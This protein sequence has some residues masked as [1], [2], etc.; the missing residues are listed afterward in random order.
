MIVF[1]LAWLLSARGMQA[2]TLDT[3]VI[4]S[5]SIQGAIA[6]GVA[7]FKGIPYARPPVGDLRW[8]PPEDSISWDTV[9]DCRNFGPH[10]CQPESALGA[11]NNFFPESENCLT[12]NVYTRAPFRSENRAVLVFVNG[13]G[14]AASGSA[15]PSLDGSWLAKKNVVAVTFNYRLGPLGF[16]A[17][18]ALS[19]ESAQN[20]SGNYGLLDQIALLKWVRRHIRSFGGDSTRVMFAGNTSG[21]DAV[22]MLMTS[23]LAANLFNRVAL[24]SGSPFGPHRHLRE[25]WYGFKSMEEAGRDLARALGCEGD[26]DPAGCLRSVPAETL[27]SYG[28]P[29]TGFYDSGEAY[30]PVVDGYVL[31]DDP[32]L[33]FEADSNFDYGMIIGTTEDDG[34]IFADDLNVVSPADYRDRL[35]PRLFGAWA[36]SVYAFFP[37]TT[38]EEIKPTLSRLVTISRFLSPARSACRPLFTGGIALYHFQR[39]SLFTAYWG[40]GVGNGME[41]PYIFQDFIERNIPWYF[42]EADRK[43]AD[44]MS[45]Y[46]TNFAIAGNPNYSI[47]NNPPPWIGELS[48]PQIQ[49]VLGDSAYRD[50]LHWVSACSLFQ[51]IDRDTR[52]KRYLS[53]GKNRETAWRP[54]LTI[55]PNPFNPETFLNFYSE[56]PGT[57]SLRVFDTRG[58]LVRTVLEGKIT[59]G[60]NRA[61]FSARGL[62]PGIYIAH[63][64]LD[65]KVYNRRMAF[66]R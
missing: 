20:V 11:P 56:K 52:E 32:A 54:G 13:S 1:L 22:A 23:P 66:L 61:C 34:S 58:R 4:E 14:F 5:G 57:A 41:V 49:M 2:Q 28:K 62:A 38:Q 39:Q 63:L 40:H 36:D 6:D 3:L 55:T 50:T 46:W 24:Q 27:L 12:V 64:A 44:H 43:L 18:P 31:P 21:A 17:H 65:G 29:R 48:S 9:L 53:A 42:D 47:P 7:S 26:P 35:L 30:G 10:C 8:K 59:M 33:E 15:Y 16:L 19:A 25:S 37:V 45:T 60:N 51:R